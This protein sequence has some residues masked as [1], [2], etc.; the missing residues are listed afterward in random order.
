MSTYSMHDAIRDLLAGREERDFAMF[1]YDQD[2]RV[3]GR[4]AYAQYIPALIESLGGKRSLNINHADLLLL[5]IMP[6]EPDAA[7]VNALIG[8]LRH[9]QHQVTLSKILARIK[10][11]DGVHMAPLLELFK[12]QDNHLT[13]LVLT[14]KQVR[15]PDAEEAVLG[16][17]RKGQFRPGYE[18]EI[19]SE[20]LSAIGTIRAIPVLAAVRLD[21]IDVKEDIFLDTMRAIFEREGIPADLQKRLSDPDTWKMDWTGAPELF[22]GFVEFIAMFMVSGPDGKDLTDQV[23]KIFMEEMKVDISPYQSFE[24]LRLCTSPDDMLGGLANLRDSLE[25]KVL[26]DALTQDAGILPSKETMLQDIYFD[27]MND[28]LMTRLRRHFSFPEDR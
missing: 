11:P 4:E 19:F 28:Y 16:Q 12:D 8:K 7:T 24:A 21:Y 23:G 22:A 5:D 17:L 2:G 20:T 10:M 3:I 1:D 25:N 18:L 26:L 9:R 14:L 15:S 13:N 27:L 6:D